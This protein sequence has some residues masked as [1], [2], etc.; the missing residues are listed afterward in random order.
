MN[1]TWDDFFAGTEFTRVKE[2]LAR[3][4]RKIELEDLVKRA[5]GFANTS[6]AVLGADAEHMMADI[7]AGMAPY[8]KAGPITERL[9][10]LGLLYRRRGAG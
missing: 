2:I 3:G 8:F 6:R 7:R 10:V 9:G 1:S 5:L 4:E